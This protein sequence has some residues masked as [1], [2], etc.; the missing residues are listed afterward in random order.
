MI[1]AQS[2]NISY[3][4]LVVATMENQLN[5]LESLLRAEIYQQIVA[6]KTTTNEQCFSC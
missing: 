4:H 6:K 1:F 2:E 5:L 3:P